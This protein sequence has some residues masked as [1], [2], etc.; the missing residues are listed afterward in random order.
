MD[1]KKAL[2][3]LSVVAMVAIMSSFALTAYATEGGDENSMMPK[4]RRLFEW[5]RQM[6][7]RGGQFGHVEVSEEFEANVINIAENDLDVQ[8]EL[9]A[10]GYSI[11]GVRPIIKSIVD[12]DGDVTTKATNAV[13]VLESEDAT[14]HAAVMVDLDEARVTK[15][16]IITRTVIEKA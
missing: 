12:A 16:V 2:I 15:I 3:L 6:R 13:V 14:S 1:R 9:L 4:F 10:Q 5:R 11:K 7:A 8:K